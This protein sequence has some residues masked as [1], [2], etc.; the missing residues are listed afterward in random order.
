MGESLRVPE[1]SGVVLSALPERTC[2][3]LP[4]S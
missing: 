3:A 4:G 1:G 2:V